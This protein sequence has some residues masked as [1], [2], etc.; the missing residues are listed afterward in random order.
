MQVIETPPRYQLSLPTL[1]GCL[2]ANLPEERN[3]PEA[4]TQALLGRAEQLLAEARQHL[5]EFLGPNLVHFCCRINFLQK[6]HFAKHQLDR[7]LS[8]RKSH[9]RMLSLTI[10]FEE[11]LK[12]ED[13]T[14]IIAYLARS[15]F[16]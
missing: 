1:L 10:A 11:S 12:D 4:Q 14:S 9:A 2:E 3:S 5:G 7:N 6:L 13:H 8:D 15:T 16:H